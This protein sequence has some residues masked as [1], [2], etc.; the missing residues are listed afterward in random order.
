MMWP[1]KKKVDFKYSD[2]EIACLN[3]FNR[4]FE[5]GIQL[6]TEIDGKVKEKLFNDA[7]RAALERLY[8]NHK[9][10]N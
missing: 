9:K 4:G 2:I 3:S 8:G 7:N 10:D 1:F 5:L 6:S